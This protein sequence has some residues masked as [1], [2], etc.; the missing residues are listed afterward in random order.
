MLDETYKPDPETDPASD[1]GPE[2]VDP[3]YDAVAAFFDE[4]LGARE[5]EALNHSYEV[6]G[7][8]INIQERDK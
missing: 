4:V 3:D 6:F 5:V 7:S 2:G 1:V 8:Q